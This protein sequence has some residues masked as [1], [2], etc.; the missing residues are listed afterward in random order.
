MSASHPV[1]TIAADALRWRSRA[2]LVLAV[3][4]LSALPGMEIWGGAR[5]GAPP[6]RPT[7]STQVRADFNGDGYGDLAVG[8][9]ADNVPGAAGT[10]HGTVSILYGS[11]RGVTL[12]DQLWHRNRASVKGV[13]SGIRGGDPREC[14]P[15]EFGRVIAIGN[16]DGDAYDDLAVAASANDAHPGVPA[17]PASV[18]VLYGSA[19]GL[20]A[21][22]DQL[23]SL[24]S[25]GVRGTPRSS[26]FANLVAGD[27]N[28][29]RRD[30]LVFTSLRN[31]TKRIHM[32]PGSPRGLTA[33]GDVLLARNTA[34]VAGSG[35]FSDAMAV[36]NFDGNR[37][38]DLAVGAF[39]SVSVFYGGARGIS[40]GRDELWNSSS[41]GVPGEAR[42][43]GNSVVG[44][45]FDGDGRDELAVGAG[46]TF[47][48]PDALV[49]VLRGTSRGLSAAGATPVIR[50]TS[51][52]LPPTK[53]GRHQF[54]VR[55]AAGDV[56]GDGRDDLAVK[57]DYAYL[58][59]QAACGDDEGFAGPGV[60]ILLKG[61][62]TG[63]S[64]AGSQ[65]V[66]SASLRFTNRD[67]PSEMC[68]L[69]LGRHI[70]FDDFDGNGNADLAFDYN[71]SGVG[72]GVAV[73]PGGA[74]GAQL[75]AAAL[76]RAE[77]AGIKAGCCFTTLGQRQRAE[78]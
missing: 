46:G 23:W 20:T 68:L 5:A 29:D 61:S 55:L 59:D 64:T 6:E 52:G 45:D 18:N 65:L 53:D 1:A 32:L 62:R 35:S 34:G 72:Q 40:A 60:V 58:P 51:N 56:T 71:A 19:R 21:S 15:G 36:G 11:A 16:F 8:A 70:A 37:A 76:W 30:D 33:V 43:F 42:S 14:C 47:D 77:L 50:H 78:F 49:L 27:F 31:S 67:V 41:P 28:G 66:G 10:E 39:R 4:V 12:V 22:G 69:G 48:T 54:G 2:L 44:G 3:A 57:D 38:D 24:A 74:E 26:D 63:I 17:Q 13:A 9:P 7:A 25:P 73:L 75:P